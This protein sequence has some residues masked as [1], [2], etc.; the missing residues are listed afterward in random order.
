[1]KIEIF[2]YDSKNYSIIVGKNKK[3]N[4]AII[5]ESIDTDVWFH[6][7]DEPSCHVILKNINK[8]RDIPNQVIKRCAYICKINSKSKFKKHCSII[9]TQIK[10]V[11]K[12]EHEG[13]V[14]VSSFKTL[15]I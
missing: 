11:I 14:A 2:N 10:N 7:N 5:D 6:V 8:L 3:E 13:Q 1:M 12:T 15:N 9:Y 4:F